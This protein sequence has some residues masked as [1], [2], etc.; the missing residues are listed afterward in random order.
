VPAAGRFTIYLNGTVS[1]KTN[2]SWFVLD[3]FV[4]PPA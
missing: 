1:K 2:V 4:L 3:P